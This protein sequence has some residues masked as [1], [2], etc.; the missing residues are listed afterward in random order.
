MGLKYFN[1]PTLALVVLS[2]AC[3]PAF[4]QPDGESKPRPEYPRPQMV[5]QQWLNLNG[6]WE[7]EIDRSMSGENK[8]YHLGA[9]FSKTITVPFCPESR[10]SGIGEKDFMQCVWYRKKFEV[11]E[12]WLGGGGKVLLHFGAVDY[13]AT[14]WVNGERAGTHR[15]GYTPFTFEISKLL[16]EDNNT[17]TVRCY[18]DTRGEL[19]PKGK[20]SRKFSS[21]KCYYTRTTG[22]WQTVWLEPV[23][24]AYLRSFKLFPDSDQGRLT[25]QARC[26]GA[27]PGMVLKATARAGNKRVGA[28][29]ATALGPAVLSMDLSKTHLWEPG[30]PFLYDLEFTLEKDGKTIDRVGSYFGLRKVSIDGRRVRIND[31]PVFQRLVLD[32]GFYPDGIYT[33]PTDEALRNDIE[34]S[35]GLGFNG[36]RCHQKV[37]EPRFFYW[38]DRLGYLVWDEFPNWGLNHSLPQA[39]ENVLSEWLEVLERDFNHPSIICWTPFNETPADQNPE[40]LRLVYQATKAVDTTRP[41]MDTSGYIHVETDIYS[42]HCYT[43]DPVKFA[44]F[45]KDLFI[46]GKPWQNYPEYD[47]PYSGQPYIVDEYG[48]IWWNPGQKDEKSWGYG[49]R[50]KTEQEF[51]S[52]YRVLTETLLSNPD[53]FGFCY[54]QLYDIEQEVNGLYTYDRKPKFEPRLIR[55]INSRPAAYERE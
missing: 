54:T 25:I 53:M 14:V 37:F 16:K 1:L 3:V 46:K 50:P 5:R 21:Y 48:G 8:D 36:A 39:L 52:R 38:A 55:E 32:Q 19:Q 28:A 26:E 22:I 27:G 4:G 43:Q 20:Q 24:A 51:L 30:D 33:A 17:L 9:P 42:V 12:D 6:A 35:L 31:K 49:N 10:L 29:R 40:L 47:A 11:P 23:P 44:S 7:F 15:G 45:F 13:E 34:I 18:D 41:V 2:L